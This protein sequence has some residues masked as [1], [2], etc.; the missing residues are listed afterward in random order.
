M[1]KNKGNKTLFFVEN[2]NQV[3][4]IIPCLAE[5]S[6]YKIISLYPEAGYFLEKSKIDY[7]ISQNYYQ[8]EELNKIGVSNF[9]HVEEFYDYLWGYVFDRSK[10][11]KKHNFNISSFHH[12]LFF[13]VL[14]DSIVTKIFIIQKILSV[15]KPSK[16]YYFKYYNDQALSDFFFDKE[17]LYFRAIE[18]IKETYS[19]L[20]FVELPSGCRENI[21]SKIK[22]GTGFKK[23]LAKKIVSCFFGNNFAELYHFLKKNP[24]KYLKSYL[25]KKDF[26][27]KGSI[28]FLGKEYDIN[29]LIEEIINYEK[30]KIIYWEPFAS[31]GPLFLYPIGL[32]CKN[33]EI[34]VGEIKY[35]K[36]ELEKIWDKI[37]HEE[38]FKKYFV[39]S[40]IDYF[41]ILKSRLKYY[42]INIISE[43]LEFYLKAEQ[44]I[45][46]YNVKIVFSPTYD[47]HFHKAVMAAC[48]KSN[49]PVAIYQHG[50][51]GY[52]DYPLGYY[53]NIKDID[54]LF[55]YGKGVE[56][57]YENHKNEIKIFSVG[58]S[59]LDILKKNLAKKF[60]FNPSKKTVIYVLSAMTAD[61]SIFPCIGYSDNGYFEIQK[62]IVEVFK[63][64][65]D[66]QFVIKL[67]PN[68]TMPET[69]LVDFIKDKNLTNCKFIKYTPFW[70]L[71]S[72]GDLFIIEEGGSTPT[73]EV[74]TTNKPVIIYDNA[75]FGKKAKEIFK[76]RAEYATSAE[77]VSQAVRKYLKEEKFAKLAN[78]DNEFL[79]LYGT[80]LDDGKSAERAFKA[81]EEIIQKSSKRLNN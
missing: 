20:E 53:C 66:I 59:R 65:P 78:P 12:Y 29:P 34:S 46:Y 48:K 58:S 67:F 72:L 18:V 32:Q 77:E 10:I 37:S 47:S 38:N 19:Y 28:L 16:I 56:K 40:G 81:T 51:F 43:I 73:L 5:N 44:L 54:Y 35:F 24:G 68:P 69:P 79:R 26:L 70:K 80:Y 42:I 13:K 52:Q 27:N 7:S 62:K 60:S 21:D 64:F 6:N 41:P 75:K 31:K 30:Y 74:L 61:I 39:Y 57:Y 36:Q 63:E 11:L 45:S 50:G 55:C 71:L 33:F 23:E 2:K 76:K 8:E 9:K 1:N 22:E 25:K 15:E 17:H 4:S 3:D 14:F 49:I